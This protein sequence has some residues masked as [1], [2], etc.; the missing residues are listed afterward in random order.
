MAG[1]R[2]PSRIA[3]RVP[4]ANGRAPIR[5]LGNS[6]RQIHPDCLRI[7]LPSTSTLEEGRVVSRVYKRPV[8]TTLQRLVLPM[9]GSCIVVVVLDSL[10]RFVYKIREGTQGNEL[11]GREEVT[12]LRHPVVADSEAQRLLQEL[13]I[14]LPIRRRFA[15]DSLHVRGRRQ[16]HPRPFALGDDRHQPRAQPPCLAFTLDVVT[17]DGRPRH[18]TPEVGPST[19]LRTRLGGFRIGGCSDLHRESIPSS[20][21]HGLDV[22]FLA[23]LRRQHERRCQWHVHVGK[24][25][26][27]APHHARP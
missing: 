22:C 21:E 27:R 1:K 8:R 9:A 6:E 3:V 20:L 10:Y 11:A 18:Q 4:G 12:P 14:R 7:R 16:I 25:R 15:S 19:Q 26:V 23:A 5:Q 2:I 24:R 17:P 13:D